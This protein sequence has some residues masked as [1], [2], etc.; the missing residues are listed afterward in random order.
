M[1]TPL[2]LPTLLL[3]ICLPPFC[4]LGELAIATNSLSDELLNVTA[5]RLKTCGPDHEIAQFIS[6]EQGAWARREVFFTLSRS[7]LDD[8][9]ATKVAGALDVFYR[10]RGYRPLEGIGGP[11]FEEINAGF[12]ARLDAVVLGRFSHFKS[13]HD[14]DVF[15]CLSLYLG[16]THAA[17]ARPQLQAIAQTAKDNEQALI[18]LAWQRNPADMD[19]LLPYMLADTPASRSLPYHFRNSYGTISIPYLRNA[20]VNAKSASTRLEA[21]FELVHLRIPEGFEYLETMALKHPQPEGKAV[22]QLDRIKMFSTDYLGLP[23]SVTAKKDV[24][25]FIARKKTELCKTQ[26]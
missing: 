8:T 26:R 18:C 13:L 11:A 6:M 17:E 23:A 16:V 1:K 19:F 15:K 10:L 9:N 22:S 5:H 7:Y 3:V 2:A 25:A 20:L 4:C 21:A 14:D 24:A 12:F